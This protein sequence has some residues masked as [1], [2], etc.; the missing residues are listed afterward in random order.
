MLLYIAWTPPPVA[1]ERF[2]LLYG[3]STASGEGKAQKTKT[4][5]LHRQ[6]RRKGQ[7]FLF[8]V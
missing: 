7:W 8:I 6:W 3:S 2:K 5:V 4:I 1:K